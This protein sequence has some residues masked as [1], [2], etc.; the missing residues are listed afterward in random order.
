MPQPVATKLDGASKDNIVGTLSIM[1]ETRNK[2]TCL[3]FNTLSKANVASWG[4]LIET[5]GT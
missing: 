1:N 2:E 3:Y 5:F 4:R